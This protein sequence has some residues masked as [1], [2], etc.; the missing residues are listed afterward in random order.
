MPESRAAI[1]HW[2]GVWARRPP[3]GMSWFEA[4]P[5]T[6]LAL[7]A[8]AG[9]PRDAAIVDAGGGASRL[10]AGLLAEGY[11]D[12]TVV[13]VSAAALAAAR[14]RAGDAAADVEWVEADVLTH[15]F[16][17]RFDLWHDRALLHFMVD[18]ADRAAY[19]QS[20]L[21][22][23]G[24]G[25]HLVVSAFGPDGPTRCSGLEVRRYDAEELSR[26]FGPG[27]ELVSSSLVEHRTPGGAGQQFLYA[28]MR[29]VSS[30]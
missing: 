28:H 23:V 17:R 12:L 22:A 4:E 15:R 13:D 1:E 2:E 18:P 16:D 19:A 25:G 14:E 27:V 8:A 30:R 7:I 5:R 24:P 20:A 6:A 3:D 26:A 29:R 11:R 10:A 21:H 9:L